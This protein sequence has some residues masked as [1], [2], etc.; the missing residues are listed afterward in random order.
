MTEAELQRAVVDLARLHH[1]K[2]AHFAPA[3]V[4]GR[5]LTPVA[6][7]G[8]GFPD[9]CMARAGRVIFAELKSAKGSLRPEQHEWV[10]E[11]RGP[12]TEVY[13]WTPADWTSGVVE[14]VLRSDV[15]AAA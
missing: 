13:V 15:R 1:W 2:V 3:Q 8:K 9:L 5:W 6:A 11:L 14:A 12:V 7:D 10:A 4:K